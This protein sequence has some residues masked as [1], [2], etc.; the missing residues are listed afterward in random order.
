M[1]KRF[2]KM[3][4]S[5]KILPAL[6]LAVALSPLA[7]QAHSNPQPLSAQYCVDPSITNPTT[8]YGGVTANAF[9][10]SMGG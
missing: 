3:S 10:D 6:A 8:I 9:R 4:I 7:A 1:Q 5:L 2:P